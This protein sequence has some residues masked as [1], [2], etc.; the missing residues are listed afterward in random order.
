MQISEIITG[1]VRRHAKVSG[2]GVQVFGDADI[3][4]ARGKTYIS[5]QYIFSVQLLSKL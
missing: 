4:L 1:V 2:V 5:Y 3:N